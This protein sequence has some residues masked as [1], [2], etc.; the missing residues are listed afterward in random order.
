VIKSTKDIIE[1]IA[2]IR[3][4]ISTNSILRDKS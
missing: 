2:M 3:D 4:L 1:S